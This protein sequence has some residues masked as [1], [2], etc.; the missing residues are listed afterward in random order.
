MIFSR[1]EKLKM[2]ETKTGHYFCHFFDLKNKPIK[3]EALLTPID[4]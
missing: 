3:L 1:I 4:A 2:L